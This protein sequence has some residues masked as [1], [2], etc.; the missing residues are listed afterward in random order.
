MHSGITYP[1]N[2]FACVVRE[3]RRFLM[4]PVLETLEGP[5]VPISAY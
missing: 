4:E 3:F 5:L 1:A 2:E